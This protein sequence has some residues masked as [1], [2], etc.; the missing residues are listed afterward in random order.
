MDPKELADK[1]EAID[2]DSFASLLRFDYTHDDALKQAKKVIV[3][4]LRFAS[5]HGFSEPH[6]PLDDAD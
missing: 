3:D 4:A 1:L 6:L 2:V 5:R